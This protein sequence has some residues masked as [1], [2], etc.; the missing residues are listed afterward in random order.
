MRPHVAARGRGPG[1]GHCIVRD[2]LRSVREDNIAV[3]AEQRVVAEHGFHHR[4]WCVCVCVCVCVL[5]ICFKLFVG[6]GLAHE[7]T[8]TLRFFFFLWHRE[9]EGDV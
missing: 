4:A 5:L 2:A 6:C 7:H 8:R 9:G 3:H 1:G